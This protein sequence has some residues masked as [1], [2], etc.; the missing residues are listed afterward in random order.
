MSISEFAS[1]DKYLEYNDLAIRLHRGRRPYPETVPY[2]GKLSFDM[3]VP[4]VYGEI[5]A[6]RQVTLSL[7]SGESCLGFDSNG[8][9]AQHHI[10]CQKESGHIVDIAFWYSGY[11]QVARNIASAFDLLAATIKLKKDL[12]V[13]DVT[14][15]MV[16]D[17]KGKYVYVLPLSSKRKEKTA[18]R[19]L[20]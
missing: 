8:S 18:W 14:S 13:D 7:K 9:A 11:P 10:L 20:P 17:F 12:P 3:L 1:W 19:Y 15:S 16:D 2:K 5:L 6:E 4:E